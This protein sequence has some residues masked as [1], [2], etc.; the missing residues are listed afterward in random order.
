MAWLG[1]FIMQENGILFPSGQ[2]LDSFKVFARE[3]ESE[4][5]LE[6]GYC[7]VDFY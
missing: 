7:Y 6:V 4:F 2:V 1:L 5:F 3:R